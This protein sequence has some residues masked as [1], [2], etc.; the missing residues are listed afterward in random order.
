MA[1]SPFAAHNPHHIRCSDHG[2]P[3][4]LVIGRH[5][6]RYAQAT[7]PVT[8]AIIPNSGQLW[9]WAPSA[10]AGNTPPVVNLPTHPGIVATIVIGTLLTFG[11]MALL[12]TIGNAQGALP[13]RLTTCCGLRSG[14]MPAYRKPDQVPDGFYTSS[15]PPTGASAGAAANYAPPTEL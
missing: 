7:D 9:R 2:L 13:E 15:P 3:I 5:L 12:F 8:G 11:N 4:G 14:G 1:F 10:S 6:Y